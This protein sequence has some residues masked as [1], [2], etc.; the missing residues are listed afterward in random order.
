MEHIDI[1]Y[2]DAYV[3]APGSFIPSKKGFYAEHI[4]EPIRP[5]SDELK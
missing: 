3:V 5:M 2:R 1:I 4:L